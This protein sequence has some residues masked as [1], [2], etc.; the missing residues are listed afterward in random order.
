MCTLAVHVPEPGGVLEVAANRD[1]FL[2]RPARPPFLWQEPRILAP[3]D[4]QA[5]GTW[6]GLNADGLFVGVTNRAGTD[7][8]PDRRS[9]GALVVDALRQRSAE[10]VHARLSS[11]PAARHNPFHLFYADRQT[12]GLTWSDG[13]R[14][15]QER[16]EPGVHLLTERSFGVG[17]EGRAE[18]L[19]RALDEDA[20]RSI[21]DL[22]DRLRQHGSSIPGWPCGHAE[23]VGYGTRSSFVLRLGSSAETSACGWSEGPPC[24]NPLVDGSALL[25]A[26]APWKQSGA[27]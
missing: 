26:L 8:A 13:E 24:R 25:R 2:A 1:E 27:R 18:A 11:L 9:R 3:R 5:G 12:A 23:A 16:V 15:F 4:E 20:P 10:G 22:W 17:D 7:R 21:E 19:A 6:L 14:L